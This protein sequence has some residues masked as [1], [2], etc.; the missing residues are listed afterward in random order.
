MPW[1]SCFTLVASKAELCRLEEQ[2]ADSKQE[3]HK[4][5]PYIQD[6]AISDPRLFHQILL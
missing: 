1:K 6:N 2:E 5:K 3:R 4:E